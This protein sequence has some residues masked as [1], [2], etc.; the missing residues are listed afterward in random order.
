MKMGEDSGNTK[1][2]SGESGGAKLTVDDKF[3]KKKRFIVNM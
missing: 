1:P 3:K 2:H